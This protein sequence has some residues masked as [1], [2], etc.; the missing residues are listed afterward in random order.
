MDPDWY[1]KMNQ[2]ISVLLDTQLLLV[3][4][5]LAAWVRRKLDFVKKVQYQ[6]LAGGWGQI[7]DRSIFGFSKHGDISNINEKVTLAYL[8]PADSWNFVPWNF[9]P[10]FKLITTSRFY[11][12]LK[13]L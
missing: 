12:F 3:E 13:Q 11:L 2:L 9:S 8:I 6:Y 10:N 1:N 4:N 7:D 5:F